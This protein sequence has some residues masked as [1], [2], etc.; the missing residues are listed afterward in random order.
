MER[1]ED[2]EATIIPFPK[3]Q[4]SGP[5][6]AVVERLR[7]LTWGDVNELLAA[8][9]TTTAPASARERRIHMPAAAAWRIR[10]LRYKLSLSGVEENPLLPDAARRRDSYARHFTDVVRRHRPEA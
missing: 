9:E 4:P 5:E 6:S 3:K 7:N 1:S 2:H 8:D 10:T